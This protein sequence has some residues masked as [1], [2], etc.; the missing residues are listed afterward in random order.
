[1]KL[2]TTDVF[3]RLS[4]NSSDLILLNDSQLKKLQKVIL[5]IADDIVGLCEKNDI[6]YHL[7]GGSTLGAVRHKGFIP[8]DDDLDID[9]ARK[10]Y[11]KLLKLIRENF[12][13][14]YYIHYPYNKDGY[15]IPYIQVRLKGTTVRGC[16]D[17]VGDECGAYI[18]IAVMENA[19]NNKILRKIHGVFSL[20]FGFIVS[21]RKFFKFRKYMLNLAKDDKEA[22]K[23]FKTKIRIG[24]LF[25]FLTLRR[26]T[27][28]YDFVN[29]ICKN[30]KSKYVCV[31]TGRRH[32][33]GEM[34]ERK[35]FYESTYSKFEGRNWKIPK[36]YDKYLKHMYGDYM[37][38]P[39]EE[40]RERHT[41]VEFK[42]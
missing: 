9:I 38:L 20:G 3:K 23:V 15:C 40:D 25:S 17:A 14:K 31:P 39:K 10:D 27:I 24:F 1:M 4:N 2:L 32:Y 12:G 19:F 34:Y 33:F 30:Q 37:K 35:D 6:V 7:T 18:D 22:T 29:R 21:C 26:W 8:W 28:I 13:D 16:N 5:S 42:I 11:D 36:E 41:L